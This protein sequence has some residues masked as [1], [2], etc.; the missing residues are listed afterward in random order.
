MD[1]GT[2]RDLY[3]NSDVIDAFI[4]IKENNWKNCRNK[5]IPTDSC[6]ISKENLK[7]KY[8]CLIKLMNIVDVVKRVLLHID[9]LENKKNKNKKIEIV[10]EQRFAGEAVTIGQAIIRNAYNCGAFVMYCMNRSVKNVCK[11]LV[12]ILFFAKK[13][14]KCL[15]HMVQ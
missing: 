2:V 13:N 14:C 8:H 4:M 6:F 15:L 10:H 1:T 11:K 9:S 3:I 7:E 12:R 5:L